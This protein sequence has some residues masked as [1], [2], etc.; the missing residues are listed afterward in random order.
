MWRRTDAT[1][2][3]V[4]ELLSG[5]GSIWNTQW[6][7]FLLANWMLISRLG[8]G[9]NMESNRTLIRADP[10]LKVRNFLN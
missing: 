10:G 9:R 4:S 8:E 2:T 3:K 1:A 5:D 6:A 7:T